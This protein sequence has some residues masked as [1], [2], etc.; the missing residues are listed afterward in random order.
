MELRILVQIKN[1]DIDTLVFDKMELVP[2]PDFDT[3]QSNLSLG[4][5]EFFH[6]V[7]NITLCCINCAMDLIYSGRSSF[8]SEIPPTQVHLT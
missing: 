2:N 7:S 5:L 4:D 8:C 3:N 1:K 6:T